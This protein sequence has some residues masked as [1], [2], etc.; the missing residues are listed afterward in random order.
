MAI[1]RII[2]L[3]DVMKDIHENIT[4]IYFPLDT[5]DQ[6]RT[7]GYGWLVH[8]EAGAISD[9]VALEMT[10]SADYCPELSFNEIKVNQ[11]ARIRNVGRVRAT[12][13]HCFIKLS[14]LKKD[15]ISK[16]EKISD[17]EIQFK[18][19]RRSTI[20]Y[21]GI[22]YSLEDDIIIRAIRRDNDYFY[23][24]SYTG[25]RANF[26]SYLQ[27]YPFTNEASEELIGLVCLV[28][29]QKYNISEKHVTDIVEFGY[30]GMRWEYDN[31]LAGFDV[32][33]KKSSIDDYVK[34]DVMHY[35]DSEAS[36]AKCLYYDDDEAGVI[37]ITNNSVLGLSLNSIVKLEIRETLGTD[38][39]I[40]VN[41]VDRPTFT[42]YRDSA[43]NYSGVY[44]NV[45]MLDDTVGAS[46]G[47]SL[48]DLKKRL[49]DA[50]VRRDNITTEHDVVSY[51]GDINANI[52]L[53]KS[54]NDIEDRIYMMYTLI[55]YGNNQ[56]APTTTK[57]LELAGIRVLD[58]L[59]NL[60]TGDF[61]KVVIVGDGYRKFLYAY[62][63]FE[64][65][66][67]SEEETDND[68]MTKVNEDLNE[69]FVTSMR[70]MYRLTADEV[71]VGDIV[72]YRNQY[73]TNA[74]DRTWRVV[75]IDNLDNENGYEETYF[76]TCPYMIMI[77][78]LNIAY[79][80]FTSVSE[81]VSMSMVQGTA[82]FPYQFVCRSVNIFRDSHSE[83]DSN[84]YY[85]TIVGLLNTENDSILLNEDDEFEDDEKCICLI[86]FQKY[87]HDIAYLPMKITSYNSETRE[88]TFKGNMTTNDYIT[89]TDL[90]EITSGLYPIH[91]N[92]E[93]Q[94]AIDFHDAIFGLTFL[95]RHDDTDAFE[96]YR[97]DNSTYLI[98][99]SD[100]D[101]YCIMNEYSNETTTPYN[102]ILEFSKFSRSSTKMTT[103]D[104]EGNYKYSI[105]SV[106]FFEY[107]FGQTMTAE[108]F[109]T[110]KNMADT[111]GSLI[112]LTTDF[113]VALKFMATYGPSKYLY[114][115]GGKDITSEETKE[116]LGDLTPTLYFKVYGAGVQIDDIYQAIYEYLRDNY[117]TDGDVFMSN[118]CTMIEKSFSKVQSIKFMGINQ[119]DAS[120]QHIVYEPPEIVNKDE[121]IKF[122]PEQLNVA[123]IEI[124]LIES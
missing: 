46:N 14:L 66:V 93:A 48:A 5:L 54:R 67:N 51:I 108:L 73:N 39:E 59:G 109:I 124:E 105:S 10:R 58:D 71:S 91:S 62:N 23:S 25:E 116:K 49:I 69:I 37:K 11:T 115:I 65:H 38:G 60:D 13:A 80:Y 84:V 68:Y 106:P 3:E 42:M 87:G 70:D 99:P 77:D 56:I 31:L 74:P 16:G 26:N 98:L 7:S 47:D 35:L 120:Y 8:A 6:N 101:Q 96:Y 95:Y 92:V 121:S 94:S 72:R 55:R 18:L 43:Y 12:P 75:D 97:D 36:T 34:A 114:V 1:K 119:F 107:H 19:D 100:Y 79:Y 112:K 50:K 27:I 40:T 122:I 2:T 33:Y 57:R 64:L 118:I 32:Y 81:E 21:G 20:L 30:D 4:K 111:Y 53:F 103:T 45:Q 88:F 117:V 28:Y 41:G 90:L 29:Q 78:D 52:Q 76:Y 63:K 89:E 24:A 17:T 44:V 9:T 22:N 15:I 102:L 83:D 104:E 110:F 123:T 85:F 61:D 113:E 86:R 82:T